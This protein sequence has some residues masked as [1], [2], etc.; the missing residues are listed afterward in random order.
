MFQ[1][2]KTNAFLISAAVKNIGPIGSFPF[3]FPEI[4]SEIGSFWRFGGI[5]A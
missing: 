1:I 3:A 2:I 4:A 5:F